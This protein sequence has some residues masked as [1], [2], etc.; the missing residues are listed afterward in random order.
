MRARDFVQ[1]MRC[2]PRQR[3][4]SMMDNTRDPHPR[5]H[6]RKFGRT[7]TARIECVAMEPLVAH[8][9]REIP[10]MRGCLSLPTEEI[11]EHRIGVADLQPRIR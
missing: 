2:T 8:D 3:L 11:R 7:T 4:H 5:T 10:Q 6:S 1:R 9:I